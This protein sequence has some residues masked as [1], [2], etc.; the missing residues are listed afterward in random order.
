MQE[1]PTYTCRRTTEPMLVDGR[2]GE[3]V[4]SRLEPVGD[5]LLADGSGYPQLRTELRICWDDR[6]L[7]LGFVAIDTDIWG[8]MRKR[9]DPIYEEEVV[10]AFLCSGDDITRYYEF[11]FSPHNVVFDAMIECPENGDRRFMTVDVGWDCEGLRSGVTVVGTA[12]DRKGLLLPDTADE[13][14]TVEAALPF[15]C[16]GRD[17]RPPSN[18]EVWRANFFRIDRAGAGEFSCWSPTMATPPSFHVPARFGVLRFSDE[19]A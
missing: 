15:P 14:W 7:Y 19:I 4:W 2:L 5:F 12:K 3:A 10:E 1:V 17:G 16:I 11:E 9:D 6:N 8:T 18:G 13:R